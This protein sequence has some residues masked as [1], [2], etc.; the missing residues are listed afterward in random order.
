MAD[1]CD[2]ASLTASLA[3]DTV[4]S[5]TDIDVRGEATS[6]LLGC[7]EKPLALLIV[8]SFTKITMD[9]LTG[10]NLHPHSRKPTS[11]N[12]RKSSTLCLGSVPLVDGPLN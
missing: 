6:W 11:H 8:L 4:I 3:H 10:S 1:V 9:Y 12:L 7:Y 5:S 2:L